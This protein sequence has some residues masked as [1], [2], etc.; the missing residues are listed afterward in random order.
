MKKL[1][2]L[3]FL[4]SLV[5]ILPSL[6]QNGCFVLA[7]DMAAQQLPFIIETKRMLASGCPF[8]SWNHV[9]GDNF[10]A[11]YSFY[12][13]TSPFVWLNCL[14]P[15]QW[16]LIGITITSLLK[17]LCTGM[18]AYA[19]LRKMSITTESSII[20]AL[21]Y[22]FSSFAI[23]NLFY[24]HFLEPMMVFP[25]LLIAIERFLRKE[26][27]GG[28]CLALAAFLVFFINY[29]F[30]LCSMIAALIY[31]LCRIGSSDIQEKPVRIIYG[32]GLV[33]VGLMLSAFVLL[34]TVMHLQGNPR[35]SIESTSI[36]SL[37]M[38]SI[39][40]LY[41]LFEP[42]LIEGSNTAFLFNPYG[43]NAANVPVVGLLLAGLYT[44]RHRGW[45]GALIARSVVLYITPL[46]EVFSLFTDPGYT[47]WAYALTLFTILASMKFVDEKQPVKIRHFWIYSAVCCLALLLSYGLPMIHRYKSYGVLFE[48]SAITLNLIIQALFLFQ[49]GLLL[50]YVRRSTSSMLLRCVVLM[51]LVYFPAR[52]MMNTDLVNKSL[53][54]TGWYGSVEKYLIDN[55]LP[56]NN[57]D[58]E[59]RTDFIAFYTNV[60]MLKN[61]PSVA[62]FNSIQN[63]RAAQLLKAIGCKMGNHTIKAAKNAVSF[64]A[65]MSVKEI[66]EYDHYKRMLDTLN[67]ESPWTEP[68]RESC[69]VNERSGDGYTIYDN[70]YYI[71]MGFTYDRF[72]C[73][74]KIDSLMANDPNADIPLLMLDNLVIP[75]SLAYVAATT[76][77][78]Q[79]KLNKTIFLD[80]IVAERRKNVCTR[81]RGNTRGFT[82]SV[83]MPH[84]NLLFFSV[85]SDKGFT[86]L[87]D[88]K[89]AAIY[90]VN[91]GLSAVM[92]GPG[93]HT[94]EFRY[95]PPG[96]HE[97]LL[98]TLAGLVLTIIVLILD[99]RERHKNDT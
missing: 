5:G 66:V 34:P 87:V 19:F 15:D 74:S 79:G 56:Y 86:A 48:H 22:A 21:M 16:M 54:R 69:M 60:S 30:A 61:R 84:K 33:G 76:T 29:Y 72:V 58:F 2:I 47:R 49:M 40:R 42:K 57:G 28:V 85:L 97:G 75:D 45:I 18:A 81:F 27:C 52:V 35:Q 31:T 8:W 43:S 32:V 82:A 14:F 77:M 68:S 24:Y 99:I 44:W 4:I 26:R 53:Y 12:T 90:P 63:P 37:V 50:A 83:F 71:P 9:I 11:S 20:G 23:S 17:M 94:I 65:L 80:S 89:P 51:S 73:Q 13:I 92:V 38:C 96:W 7:T 67:M 1:C 78:E 41:T 98:I 25:I 10:I 59:W 55:R 91:L 6:L 46:N 62:T 39:E 70:K 95:F 36:T 93:N 88:G 3:I 64:D